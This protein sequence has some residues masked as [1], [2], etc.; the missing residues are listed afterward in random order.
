M[1]PLKAL[2]LLAIRALIIAGGT[3]FFRHVEGWS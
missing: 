3:V 2:T 1:H